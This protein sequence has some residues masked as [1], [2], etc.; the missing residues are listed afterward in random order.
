MRTGPPTRLDWVACIVFVACALLQF[1]DPDTLPWIALYLA[2]AAACVLPAPGIGRVWFPATVGL[3]ALI[4]AIALLP[5]ALP[6]LRVGELFESMK[7]ETPRIEI[8]REALGLL[9]VAAWMAV[10]V[11]RRRRQTGGASS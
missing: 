11:V 10:P 3:A 5:Q 7:A 4:W 2:A 9:L 8:A 1:N 6:G